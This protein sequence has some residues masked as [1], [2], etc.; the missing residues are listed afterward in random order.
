MILSPR[1]VF[2]RGSPELEFFPVRHNANPTQGVNFQDPC[3]EAI[4][5][6][7]V[8]WVLAIWTFWSLRNSVTSLDCDFVPPDQIVIVS[9]DG[10]RRRIA[11]RHNTQTM[12]QIDESLVPLDSWHW[13]PARGTPLL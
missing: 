12:P 7:V 11:T 13:I 10:F 9:L 8:P 4:V 6:I 5:G 2:L 1:K 3:V